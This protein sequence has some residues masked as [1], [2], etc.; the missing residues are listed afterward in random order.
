MRSLEGVA[1]MGEIKNAYKF[2]VEIPEDK[3]PVMSP[4][5]RW[6]DNIKIHL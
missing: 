3:K 1:C 5:R 2:L 6:E 4:R